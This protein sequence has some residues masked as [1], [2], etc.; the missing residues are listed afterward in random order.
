MP[1]VTITVAA[2]PVAISV[3][4][5]PVTVEIGGAQ[6]PLSQ[7]FAT[8]KASIANG[9]KFAMLD[10]AASDAPKHA[11]WSLVK[12]TLK[13]YFDTLY[14]TVGSYATAAQGALADTAVQPADISSMVESD[15]S[16][17]DPLI[18]GSAGTITNVVS[19]TQA[20]YD[21]IATP[22]ATTLYVIV[23]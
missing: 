21:E 2:S 22:S 13:T 1:D 5:D 7:S 12:S 23:E 16:T 4:A 10:S 18:T 9:D 17:V 19:L 20:Q 3:E 14:Q 6:G 15:T 11:L 8:N